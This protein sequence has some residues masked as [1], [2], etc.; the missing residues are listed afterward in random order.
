MTILSIASTS[1]GI[2][3]GAKPLPV[4]TALQSRK[5][6]G[7]PCAALNLG[8][9][10]SA[11]SSSALMKST[12]AGPA[13]VPLHAAHLGDA[14]ARLWRA[15]TV[16]RGAGRL[17]G[18]EHAAPDLRARHPGRGARP[19]VRRLR[20]TAPDGTGRGGELRESRG[21]GT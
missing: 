16:G 2:S 6:A 17:V 4:R 3:R 8:T 14:C 10:V 7:S 9:S 18:R 19:L 15:G 20:Q 1:S 5:R 21:V 11:A 12:L 13:Q